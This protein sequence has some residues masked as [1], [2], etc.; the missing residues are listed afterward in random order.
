M[1]YGQI[2]GNPSI[3]AAIYRCFDY[4]VEQDARLFV[5]KF[6]E[7]VGDNEQVMHT[8]RELLVG[9]FLAS[10][11]VGVRYGQTIDGVNARLVRGRHQWECQRH[12]GVGELSSSQV[13]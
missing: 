8:F 6:R 7:Q 11:G 9:G 4:L 5:R 12:C 13:G 10:Q 2:A 3:N 1:K